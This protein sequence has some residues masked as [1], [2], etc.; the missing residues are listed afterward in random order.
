LRSIFSEVKPDKLRKLKLKRILSAGESVGQAL[1]DAAKDILKIPI[2][3]FYSQTE[4]GPL[5]TNSPY[6]FPVVSGSC[7][8]VPP[9]VKVGIFDENLQEI[10]GE[11]QG[12]L[13]VRFSAPII[14]LGYFREGFGQKLVDGWYR[15]GDVLY[16]TEDGYFFYIGRKDYIIKTSGYR[17][18][19]E[20]IERAILTLEF[21]ENCA[22]LPKKDEKKGYIIKAVVKL[23]KPFSGGEILMKKISDRVSE[24]IG[25]HVRPREIEFVDYIP[26]TPTGKIKRDELLKIFS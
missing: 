7:G 5:I 20:E 22:V 1:H 17:I 13:W 14:M 6:F 18:S 25:P 19:P 26:L 21:V 8:R 12:E 11:G 10:K 4:A 15:T 23:K 24:L 2:T 3:E 9:G 16:R